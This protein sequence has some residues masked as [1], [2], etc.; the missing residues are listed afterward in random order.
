[1]S[2]PAFTPG[3]WRA[4]E[5]AHIAEADNSYWQIDAGRGYF[6]RRDPKGP[7]GFSLQGFMSPSDAALI[8]AAP[9]LYAALEQA[10]AHIEQV[11]KPLTRDDAILSEVSHGGAYFDVAAARAAL[12]KVR[13]ETEPPLGALGT[14]CDADID[15]SG[16]H[17]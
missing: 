3:P 4:S 13:G 1:M 14:P 2:A 12:A 17:Q 6:G 15:F 10:V 8:A 11:H 16:D 7:H 9:E 5:P